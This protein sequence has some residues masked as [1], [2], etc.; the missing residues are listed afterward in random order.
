MK[1]TKNEIKYIK[2][3]KSLEYRGNLLKSTTRKN[4]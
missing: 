1:E 4:Y 3:I 2:L